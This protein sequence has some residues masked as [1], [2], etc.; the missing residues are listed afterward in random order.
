MAVFF[1]AKALV[2]DCGGVGAFAEI[3]GRTRTSP[4]RAIR[5]GYVSTLV[6]ARILELHPHL[7]INNYFED[8]E[9]GSRPNK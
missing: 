8:S 7:N 5:T 1:D 9:H 6:L 4:Y 3:L 2:K